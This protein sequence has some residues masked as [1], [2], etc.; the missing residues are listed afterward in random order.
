MPC[1]LLDQEHYD[2]LHDCNG[3]IVPK[4]PRGGG[5]QF[6]K[7]LKLNLWVGVHMLEGLSHGRLPTPENTLLVDD[8][9]AKSILNLPSN[10]IFP[11]PWKCDIND[12]ILENELCYIKRLAYHP[13]SVLDFVLSN[14]I[15]NRPL[16]P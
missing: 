15:G 12:T 11:D 5:P 4:V 2:E 14:P 1:L 8:N 9:P 7:V 6:L 16:G 3:K 13:R 10:A